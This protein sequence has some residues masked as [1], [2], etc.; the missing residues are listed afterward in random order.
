[1]FRFVYSVS[2]CCSVYCLCVHVYCTTAT[3]CQPNYSK[4]IYHYHHH[5]E[6]VKF[7]LEQTVKTQKVVEVYLY[8][9]YNLGARWEWVVNT[10]RQPLYLHKRKAVAILQ[11]AGWAA[12]PL[13]EFD[14]RT[15]QPVECRYTD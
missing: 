6:N 5:H 1:M 15:V 10:T 13:P 12:G 3:G 11:E 7:T 14:P 4:Q 2:L 9:L 8:C